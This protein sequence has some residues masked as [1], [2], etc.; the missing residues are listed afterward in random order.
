QWAM[1]DSPTIR[2]WEADALEITPSVTPLR[3]GGH[4]A[5]GTV[6][7]WQSGDGVLMAGDILQVT[8]GKDAV[9]SMWSYP[10]MLPL[11]ARTVEAE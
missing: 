5:G 11:P 9:S 6:P 4:F 1:R 10:T 7:P 2:F 8:P 3:P